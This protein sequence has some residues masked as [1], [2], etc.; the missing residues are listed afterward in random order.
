MGSLYGFFSGVAF[1]LS[2]ILLIIGAG[3]F[4]GANHGI[5]FYFGFNDDNDCGDG[6]G[7]GD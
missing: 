1:L 5:L 4:G 6:D 7:G 2:I 3:L